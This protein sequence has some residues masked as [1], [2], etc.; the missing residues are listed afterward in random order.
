VSVWFHRREARQWESP[1]LG[2]YGPQVAVAHSDFASLDARQWDTALQAVAVSSAVDLVASLGSELPLR[3]FRG[4]G[5]QRQR[6]PVPAQLR[7]PAGDGHGLADWCYR[8]LMSW[9]MR[10]NLFG[11]ALERGPGRTLRQVELFHP[12]AVTGHM[13][14][15]E[16]RFYV[17]GRE[18]PAASVVHRRVFPVPGQIVGRSPIE[19][20][21][22]T[23]GVN[24][25]ST[26]YG[27]QW[28]REGAHP[29]GVLSST[30]RQVT[31]TLAKQ[32]KDRF[33]AALRGRR[34][35]VVLDRGWEWN[36]IQVNPEES[37]FLQTQGYSAAE[38]ARI[39]GPGIAE[40]LGYETGGSLT[41]SNY[42]DRD[43]QLL[44][45]SMDKWLRRLERML[46]E[47]LPAP[48]YVLL[49]R[50][51]LLRTNTLA[52]YSTHASALDKRWRTVN[53]V[54]AME[55]LPPVPWGDEPNGNLGQPARS[56][57]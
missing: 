33:M 29:S 23:I 12:D 57:R 16:P 26:A 22:S 37:Q 5:P 55:D 44:K 47:F 9:L 30:E 45:Y 39:F 3:V 8:V 7:D 40:V 42:Q 36:S 56:G 4:E 46:G 6:L 25:S 49:N 41:Y 17:R 50:D 43:I 52:R 20:H 14:D 28:F 48:Q 13:E 53:E 51:A 31:E 38:C 11:E 24:L 18:I 2:S 21:A 10:G 27:S 19:Y 32:V 34:E 54:R 1:R 15:G 35:P